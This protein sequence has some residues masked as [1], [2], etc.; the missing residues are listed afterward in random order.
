MKMFELDTDGYRHEY[1]YIIG[2]PESLELANRLHGMMRFDTHSDENGKYL[3]SSVYFD[4]AG[5]SELY[6]SQNG[7]EKRKKY[8]IRAYGHDDS[9][10]SLEIKEKNRYLCKKRSLRIDRRV[11]DEIMYG[12]ASILK[13][14]NNEVADEF[15]YKL[16]L[17]GYRPKTVVEYVRRAFICDTQNVRITL[18]SDI[19]GSTLGADMFKDTHS[20][21]QTF[22]PTA[23]VLEVKYDKFLPYHI[24]AVLPNKLY[25]RQSVSKYVY[26]RTFI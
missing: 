23:Q 6:A 22:S 20:L 16:A 2:L 11:Y 26:G 10:I 7:E 1:K 4:S 12:D 14:L 15:Y 3:I 13:E 21:T 18:D 5:S 25:P 19:K 8:R 9:F 24:M 17:E